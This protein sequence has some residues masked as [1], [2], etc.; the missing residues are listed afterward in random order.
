MFPESSENVYKFTELPEF[1]EIHG[2]SKKIAKNQQISGNV[3][4]FPEDFWQTFRNFW[5]L[6]V[7]LKNNCVYFQFLFCPFNYCVWFYRTE[8]SVHCP[9]GRLDDLVCTERERREELEYSYFMEEDRTVRGAAGAAK[10]GFLLKI[11]VYNCY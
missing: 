2:I 11:R 10:D 7:V 6:R 4:N 5:K 1:L 8:W 9:R 3:R